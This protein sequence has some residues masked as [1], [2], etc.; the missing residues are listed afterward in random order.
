[1]NK[2]EREITDQNEL[3]EILKCG[4]FTVISMCRSNE[5]YIVTMTYGY[6]ELKH[7]LYF[8]AATKG[9]KLDFMRDNPNVCATVIDDM[10]YVQDQ[11]EHHYRSVVFWGKMYVVD[12]LAEKKHGL[13][14]LLNHQEKEPEPIK[15]RNVK[16]DSKYDK[17]TI[18][19][20]VIDDIYGKKVP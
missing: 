20:L 5:P 9:L 11:C 19:K 3:M 18:L 1:M 12:D 4:R 14:V 10:G 13:D 6:D 16:D 17:V 2:S 7:A 15:R 8:H